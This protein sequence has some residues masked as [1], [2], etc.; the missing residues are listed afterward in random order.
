MLRRLPALAL[1]MLP[2]LAA[3]ATAT[4]EPAGDDATV[5]GPLWWLESY[6]AQLGFS[7]VVVGALMLFMRWRAG[8]QKTY[9]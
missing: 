2:T 5:R 9:S 3:A 7:I 6:W 4:A 8:R 1:V